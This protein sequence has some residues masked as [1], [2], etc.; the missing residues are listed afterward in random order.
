VYENNYPAFRAAAK[1]VRPA[2][3]FM[4]ILARALLALLRTTGATTS[5]GSL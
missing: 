1:A 2:E 5:T 4:Q 3:P